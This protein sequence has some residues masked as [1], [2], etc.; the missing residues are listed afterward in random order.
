[1]HCRA[2][3]KAGGFSWSL[4][5]LYGGILFLMTHLYRARSFK[6]SRS[7]RIDSKEMILPAYVAWRATT[8]T[9]FLL[10]F[11]IGPIDCLKITALM[12]Q[13]NL[14][15]DPSGMSSNSV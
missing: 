13:K 4:D 6:L 2:F 8:T 7:P 12:V 3:W 1:M 15:Q 11:Y 9:L 10:G 5:A 14:G